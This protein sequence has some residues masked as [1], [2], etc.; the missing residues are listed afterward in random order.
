MT[1]D[2]KPGDALADKARDEF[3]KNRRERE[4]AIERLRIR[5]E[6]RSENFEEDSQVIHLQAAQNIAQRENSELPKPTVL[7]VVVTVFKSFP[8]WGAVLVALAAIAAYAW[9]KSIGRVP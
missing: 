6:M 2:S 9:L 5:S 7:T 8:P 3:D 1:G 4:L